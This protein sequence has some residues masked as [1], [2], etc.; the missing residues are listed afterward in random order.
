MD[1]NVS[2]TTVCVMV[3]RDVTMNLMKMKTSAKVKQA[4]YNNIHNVYYTYLDIDDLSR[5]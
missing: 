4:I 3:G 5:F 1:F 2:Q